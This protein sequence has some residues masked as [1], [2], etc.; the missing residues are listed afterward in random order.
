MR[1]LISLALASASA[2]AMASSAAA[3]TT[4]APAAA[5]ANEATLG[6]IVVTARR[7]AESLQEVP[8]TVNA[9]TSDTLQKL[10]IRQFQDIQT[11]APGLSL[12]QSKS[13]FQNV[14]SLRGITFNVNTGGQISTVATYL[15][16]APMQ[17]NQVF[18]SMFDIGQVEILKGPQG[19]TRGVSAPSGAITITTHKPDLSEFGGYA[20]VT[21]TDHQGRN[22]QGAVNIPIVKDMLAL[23]IAGLIDS[24]TGDGVTSIHN[25]LRPQAKTDAMRASL[26]FEPTD[27][28]NANIT[29]QHLDQ[30]LFNFQ[31]VTGPGA[32][33]F[34]L[35]TTVFPASVNPPLT[36]EDRAAVMD[37]ANRIRNHF[38][39]V[40]VQLDSRVFGQH[41]SYVGSYAHQA[42]D[43][44]QESGNP[45][46]GDV[47]NVL[48]GIAV[49]QH[50]RTQSQ[51]TTQEFRVASDPAPGR[52]FDYTVGGY[53]SWQGV[54]GHI[55]Q[56]GPLT[57]GAFGSVPGINLAA[58]N[59][60]YQIP[61]TIEIPRGT[62]ETSLFGS[63][64]LHLGDKTELSGGIRHIWA[65]DKNN[66][67]IGVG[68]LPLS[69]TALGL[70]ATVP[71]SLL[72]RGA[73]AGP[74]PGDCILPTASASQ[75]LH[76]V[77]DTPNI[78]NVSLSHHFTRDFLAYV[79]TGTSYRGPTSSVGIQGALFN[80]PDPE[81]NLLTNHPAERSRAYEIGIK[82]TWL[83]GRARFNAAAFRQRFNNLTLYVPNIAFF[84]TTGT[85]AVSSFNFT[86]SVDALVTGFD[87]DGA[88]QI[89]PEW[90]VSAQMS[91]AHSQIEGSLV[92]CNVPGATLSATNL[93]SLCPGGSASQ[94][95]LWNMSIQSEYDHPLADKMDGFLRA[96]ATIYPENK[97]VE[98]NFTVPNYSLLNL[99]AGVR[100]RDGA[101]EASIFVRNALNTLVALDRSP[102]QANLNTSLAT[103]FPQ[104][105]HSTGYYETT[106]N[107]PREVGINV[108]YAF[109]SR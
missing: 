29:Y 45:S 101:W 35:G 2:A 59:A 1:R 30:Q 14:A 67:V 32:G 31:Q 50:P 16:D 26:S 76:R 92:P 95:P 38:D 43:T 103:F 98:S 51:N 94:L 42:I 40:T 9:V 74:N 53:Y 107:T 89:T 18:Q 81:L 28:F 47:G 11:V 69:L 13:G 46:L 90:N 10:N 85:G 87:L 72:S 106:T 15:N 3:Q 75:N 60:F 86:T 56:N 52:F 108:H 104:L 21:V 55:V 71:C 44:L 33:T 19:T 54:S 73:T 17:L 66:T 24:N 49:F 70:P 100:S 63:V 12:Q 99:Y 84:N 6:E 62:Q 61:I 23:R 20:D 68:N 91:Y 39:V 34:T 97:Y 27:A 83:D 65:I 25:N 79:N 22:A 102:V 80:N 48:P 37:M 7:R 96:L 4:S 82:S 41:L 57:P 93:I 5:P 64:T 36:A 58:Y 77:S 105:I 8:Q 88:F 78:Y 109:G